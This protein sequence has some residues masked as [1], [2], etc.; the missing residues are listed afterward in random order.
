MVAAYILLGQWLLGAGNDVWHG[1]WLLAA[2][3]LI[4]AV[5]LAYAIR[6]FIDRKKSPADLA[7]ALPAQRINQRNPST[8]CMS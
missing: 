5:F 6:T 1:R 4:N 3:S 7:T 2:F 8:S